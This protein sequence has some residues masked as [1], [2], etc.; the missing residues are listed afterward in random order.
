MLFGT[1]RQIR[2]QMLF[3]T[4]RQIRIQMLFGTQ[5]KSQQEQPSFNYGR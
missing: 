5:G 3:G 4:E 2:I 1:E